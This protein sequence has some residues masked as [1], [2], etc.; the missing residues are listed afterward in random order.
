[1]YNT[2]ILFLIFNRPDTTVKVFERIREIQPARLY[3]AADGARR[4]K[5]GE[6]EKCKATRAVIDNVDWECEVKTLFREE[7]LGCR[8]AVS[9][10]ISWFF[11]QE[12]QGVILEDDCLPDLSFF[13]YCEELLIRYK[14]DCRIGNISGN[15]FLPGF[16]KHGLS[17]DFSSFAHIWGWATWRRVWKHFD[18]QFPYW[19][20]SEKNREMRSSLFNSF[21]EK[22]Y[23]SSY[24]SDCL[25]SKEGKSVWDLQY[26]YTLRV[27]NQL[28]VYPSVNLVANIGLNDPEATHTASK[29]HL[30][31][32]VPPQAI[33]FPLKHPQYIIRNHSLDSAVL[34]RNF[35]SWKRLIRYF[36]N[37]F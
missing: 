18:I 35:F 12:E 4:H 26:L 23:F 8:T 10:A 3:V 32:Y 29:K 14:D 33:P 34:R 5:E 9:S 1:M 37:D 2:A 36:L 7:N 21:A 25:Q 31:S 16:V 30:K 22:A 28:S 20:E 6:D 19:D 15:N 17:Y 24:I 13:P 11:E 27:Q